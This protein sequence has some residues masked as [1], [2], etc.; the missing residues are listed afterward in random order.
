MMGKLPQHC[1]ERFLLSL[2]KTDFEQ[3]MPTA[4]CKLK[5]NILGYE[6][7]VE[8]SYSENLLFCGPPWGVTTEIP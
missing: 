5:Q 3:N 8:G 1:I 4:C 7:L 6:G 2:C